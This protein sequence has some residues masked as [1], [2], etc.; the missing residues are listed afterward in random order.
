MAKAIVIGMNRPAIP[1]SVPGNMVV[2]IN[3]V[4]AGAELPTVQAAMVKIELAPGETAISLRN[5]VDAAILADATAKGFTVTQ[6]D[7]VK[8]NFV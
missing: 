6:S 4:Y 7:I 8:P 1:A 5:K 3:T 2:H